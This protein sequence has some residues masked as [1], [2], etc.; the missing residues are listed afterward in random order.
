MHL[1][2]YN[3]WL[4]I[5]QLIALYW[6]AGSVFESAAQEAININVDSSIIGEITNARP[7]AILTFDG[8]AGQELSVE[9]ISIS[10]SLRV[11][12]VLFDE[13]NNLV[14]A[15]GN[16]DQQETIGSSLTL[17]ANGLYT[18]QVSSSNNSS[19]EF[20]LRLSSASAATC[21]MLIDDIVNTLDSVCEAT[22][23]N[24][25]C[26]GNLQIQV[27]P[28]LDL[29]ADTPFTF[30]REGDIANIADIES[31]QLSPLNLEQGV[32]GLALMQV[33]ADLP[34][35]LPGQNVT[36]LFFGDVQVINNPVFDPNL[37]SRYL[38][39]QSFYFRNG[40]GASTCN[41]TPDH[42]VLISTPEG[43]G[44]IELTINEV[45]VR[46]GSTLYIRQRSSDS[47]LEF[48]TLD[49]RAEIEVAGRMQVAEEGMRVTV[50][51][52]SLVFPAG[53][54]NPP[55]PVD[56][57]VI[58][59]LP[60]A[61]LIESAPNPSDRQQ[62]PPTP[63]V[64]VVT[65]DPTE[66]GATRPTLPETGPCV[67]TTFEDGPV[68]VRSG[69]ST[70]DNVVNTIF[71]TRTYD[72]LGRT[73]EGD[74]FQISLGWVAAF[75]TARGGDCNNVPVTFVEPTPT[76]A[77]TEVSPPPVAGDNETAL[78]IDYNGGLQS[79]GGAISYPQGDTQD[80]VSYTLFNMPG[81]GFTFDA[82]PTNEP[83]R[84]LS[85][86][87]SCA[88]ERAD[89]VRVLFSGGDTLPCSTP[90]TVLQDNFFG[91]QTMGSF[92]FT[93]VT[94]VPQTRVNWSATIGFID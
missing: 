64:P 25:V 41:E 38:P 84:I 23:R 26:Y 42:G 7:Q 18:I 56:R 79:V 45:V 77:A 66:D 88:G 31:M 90:T 81:F 47:L 80:T 6:L 11:Q 1:L 10:D 69:P 27:Q 50:P 86:T 75:V 61:G 40:I 30:E 48:N 83:A 82:P 46:V 20:V 36:I 55:E 12:L 63:V 57:A 58:E 8:T 60:A 34:E 35:T 14:L 39:M 29:P 13:S 5:M 65:E 92:T 85:I 28:R 74:W 54:P 4:F 67:L 76:P 91:N 51:V 89:A 33:Q 70:E 94:E 9:L 78:R 87:V 73:V 17:P 15:I 32:W 24:Q 16:P 37:R 3:R 52:D 93:F 49:G 2:K 22:G 72:V 21:E 44:R 68:N 53:P 62:P 59:G 71:P 43:A 19:G